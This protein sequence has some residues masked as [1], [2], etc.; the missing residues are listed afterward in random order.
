[1]KTEDWRD[2]AYCKGRNTNDFYPEFG[3]KGAMDQVRKMKAFCRKCPVTLNCL[4]FAIENDEQFG[5]WGGLTPKERNN[6]RRQVIKPKIETIVKVVRKN[7]SYE[8]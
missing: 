3:V 5:I 8:V 1:M 2:F 6:L 4:Q 7:D